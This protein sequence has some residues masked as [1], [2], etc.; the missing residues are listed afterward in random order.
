V[1]RLSGLPDPRV[2]GSHNPG[3]TNVLRMGSKLAA[4]ITL[5]GD[6]AKG[7]IPVIIARKLG[8]PETICALCGFCA[9]IGHLYPVY[10]DFRGGK[11]VAT[12]L[13]VLGVLHWPTMLLVGGIWLAVFMSTRFSSLASIAA[14]LLAPLI[15]LVTRPDLFLP[16]LVLSLMLLARHHHNI[17]LLLKGEEQGFRRADP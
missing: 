12:A 17:M 15:T 5:A 4:G 3:A 1:C 11:G 10:F 16:I 7:I 6:V 2:T 13:G 14:F 8:L 9:F